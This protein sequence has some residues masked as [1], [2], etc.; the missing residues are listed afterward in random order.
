MYRSGSTLTE[1]LLAGNPQVGAGGELTL[2]PSMIATEMMPFPA[3]LARAPAAQLARLAASYSE[4]IAKLY[5]AAAVVTDKRPDN[6]FCI[7]FIK[8][9]FPDAQIVHTTRDPLDTCLSVYFLHLDHHLSYALDLSDI[10]HFYRQYRRL[11]AHWK[12]RFGP[13]IIDFDYDQFVHARRLPLRAC[14]T[15]WGWRGIPVIWTS[16]AR[17]AASAPR[18]CGRYAEPLYQ[19]SS[20]RARN[21]ARELAPLRAQLADLLPN[22]MGAAEPG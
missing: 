21:Y 10:G 15:R 20:G 18:A 8:S 3:A 9:L 13:S 22:G 11:M 12:Q 2:L 6:F 7:G 5:P 16:G 19:Y 17:P 14:S 4:N 1:R